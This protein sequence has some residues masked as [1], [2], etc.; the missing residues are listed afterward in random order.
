MFD[1][2]RMHHGNGEA[3][4]IGK[5]RDFTEKPATHTYYTY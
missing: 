5:N 2:Q 3:Y 4:L 1:D